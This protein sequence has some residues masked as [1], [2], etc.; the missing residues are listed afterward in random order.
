[1]KGLFRRIIVFIFGG[2]AYVF[3][4]ILHH[5]KSHWSMFLCGGTCIMLG[6]LVNEKRP[7]M[8]ILKQSFLITG[9]ILVAEYVTGLIVNVWLKLKVWDYTK[10]KFNLNGQICLNY[11]SVWFLLSPS[12]IWFGDTLRWLL[13]NKKKPLSLLN[14]YRGLVSTKKACKFE[15]FS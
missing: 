11:A 4:E 10:F 2:I 3:L 12:L 6:D 14:T 9:I 5:G 15:I 1:M 7:K 8:S 13:F